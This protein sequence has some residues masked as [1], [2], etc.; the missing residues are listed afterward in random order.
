MMLAVISHVAI[1]DRVEDKFAH[2]VFNFENST[3]IAADIPVALIPCE[4]SEGDTLY[5][6]KTNEI[7]EIRCA[8]FPPPSVE[9]IID[10]TNGGVQY[11]I[12]NIPLG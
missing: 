10:P 3:S 6:R 2:I 5:V 7:T 1:V 11:I 9:I 4:I 12:K 8:E